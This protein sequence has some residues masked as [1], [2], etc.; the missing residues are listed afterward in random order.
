MTIGWV[1][2]PAGGLRCDLSISRIRVVEV[3]P[4]IV[5]RSLSIAER[6][7]LVVAEVWRKLETQAAA[8]EPPVSL[9]WQKTGSPKNGG[10]D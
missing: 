1:G 9:L 2:D 5:S 6:Q 3:V 8:P 7:Q 4:D 10:S